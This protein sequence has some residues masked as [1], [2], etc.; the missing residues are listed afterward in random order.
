MNDIPEFEKKFTVRITDVM[1]KVV[2]DNAVVDRHKLEPLLREVTVLSRERRRDFVKEVVKYGHHY[3]IFKA[4]D[5]IGL[6]LEVRE[7]VERSTN[8]CTVVPPPAGRC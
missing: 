8:E 4:G 6:Y 3:Y 5:P 7:I 1:G 2:V